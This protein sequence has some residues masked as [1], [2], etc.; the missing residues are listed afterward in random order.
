MLEDATRQAFY[1][2]C[3]ELGLPIISHHI[4]GLFQD[5]RGLLD[6]LAFTYQDLT[7][8]LGRILAAHPTLKYISAHQNLMSEKRLDSLMNKYPNL[9]TDNS[10]HGKLGI[11]YH[12]KCTWRDS[13]RNIYIRHPTR[14]MLG[15]DITFEN[16]N[17]FVATTREYTHFFFELRLPRDVLNKIAHKNIEDLCGVASYPVSVNGQPYV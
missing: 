4:T 3:A 14:F 10:V 1:A 9:Y 8:V 6:P 2:K 16:N 13:L 17:G 7:D 11:W 5:E 15:T 12:L